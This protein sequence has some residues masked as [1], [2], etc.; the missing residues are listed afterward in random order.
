MFGH[1]PD[2]LL[3]LS[4]GADW[5]NGIVSLSKAIIEG[6]YVPPGQA[7]VPQSSS[8]LPSPDLAVTTHSIANIIKTDVLPEFS[9]HINRAIAESYGS[10]LSILAPKHHHPQP[11]SLHQNIRVHTHPFF[12]ERLRHFCSSE[13]KL[14][15]F[16]GAAQAEVTQLMFDG[17]SNVGYFAATGE[18]R[19]S[20]H[21]GITFSYPF[22]GSGKTTPALLNATLDQGKSTVWC[23]PL[24]SMHEQYHLRC[25]SHSMTC[26]S[27]THT[28]SLDHPP[29]HI[30]VTIKHTDSHRF[31]DFMTRLVGV[32]KAARAVIDEAHFALTHDSFRSIMHTLAWLGSMNCQIILL[33]ATIGPSLVEALF[34]K[35]GI[36]Q[37]VVCREKKKPPEHI[38]QH[39][40][41]ATSAPD[42][43]YPG[44]QM[45]SAARLQQSYYLL[46][47]TGGNRINGETT[48][49]TFLPQL[50]ADFRHQRR[51]GSA[52]H[53]TGQD[54]HLHHR[55]GSRIGSPGLEMG[56]PP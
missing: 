35:F 15:G 47:L 30:L 9:L 55:L 20:L 2:L 22:P 1:P 23:L 52:P 3:A 6:R 5:Q 27:W 25:K 56:I 36:T 44:L 34:K 13:D 11:G 7:V 54:C 14:L 33:S 19:P 8:I 51:A 41:L 24:K 50:N 12:L 43:G 37:Y 48:R 45:F 21:P 29:L 49:S 53:W 28:T 4:Q 42:P 40:S 10:V 39:H 26:E 38:L 46:P 18:C 17:Q 32:R 16:T 31:H